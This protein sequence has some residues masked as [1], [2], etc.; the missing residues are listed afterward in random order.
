MNNKG[1]AYLRIYQEIRDNIVDG[2]YVYGTKL[3]SKRAL[4]DSR[5]VSVITIQRAYSILEDEGYIESR[6]RSGY[7]VAYKKTDSFL[8]FPDHE[9]PV[10][11][12]SDHQVSED[13]F[14][15]QSYAKAVRKVLSVSG[16]YIY[17]RSPN[18]GM[19]ELRNAIRSYLSRSKNIDVDPSQII[20]GS[21]SEYLYGMLVLL[22]GHERIYALERPSYSQIRT[23]YKSLGVRFE[24][25]Q[26]GQ[27]G[28]LSSELAS[29]KAS[30]LHVTPYNSYPSGISASASK[31]YEYIRWAEKDR[32]IIE[33]D[34]SS[35]YSLS[36]KNED[37]LF[38]LSGNDNIIYL[39]SFSRTIS[40][41]IRVGYMVLP[42][43]LCEDY[44][45]I[46]G[47]YSCTVPTLEQLVITELLDSGE[48]E[49]HINRVRRAKR[50]ALQKP[51]TR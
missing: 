47:A 1:F 9:Q 40:P 38:L 11:V 24:E 46:V 42:K 34:Y 48:F 26:M 10:S 30:V 16:E 2:A 50:K 35:E 18:T 7:F 39:N 6:E 4:A 36:R 14:P 5:N 15:L 27:D 3:P 23:I 13:L 29:S 17:S 12:S 45:R 41:S 21:G 22:L 32:F 44:Y 25:L 33:D 37:T 49:R 8:S 31:R 51:Q 28:I 43:K 20:V 19:H